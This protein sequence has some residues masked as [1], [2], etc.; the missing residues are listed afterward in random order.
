M[1]KNLRAKLKAA[2]AQFQSFLEDEGGQAMPE[3]GIIVAL[4]AVVVVAGAA[5]LGVR[6]LS[7]F[8]RT[9]SAMP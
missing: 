8:M 7:T 2:G 1:V 3:Y 5:Y 4:I 9:G 6:V